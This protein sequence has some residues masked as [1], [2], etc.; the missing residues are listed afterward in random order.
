MT[1]PSSTTTSPRALAAQRRRILSQKGNT[2]LVPLP[3]IML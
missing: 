3:V 2:R 1:Q